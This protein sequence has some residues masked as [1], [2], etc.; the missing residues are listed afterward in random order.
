MRR[1]LLT[2]LAAAA[3]VGVPTAVVPGDGFRARD[4][5]ATLMPERHAGK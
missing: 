3:I 2:I 4:Y 5:D 1:M